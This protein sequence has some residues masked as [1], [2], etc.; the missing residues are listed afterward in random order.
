MIVVGKS[1]TNGT[2]IDIYKCGSCERAYYSKKQCFWHEYN[3]EKL[4]K[5]Q[6]KLG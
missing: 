6:K 1:L 3:C 4:N 5:E 2:Y